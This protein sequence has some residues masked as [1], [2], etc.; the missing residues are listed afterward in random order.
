M[1]PR[2]FPLLTRH[3]LRLSPSGHWIPVPRSALNR[4][5]H[6]A[7]PKPL[8]RR[9]KTFDTLASDAT[10]V[11]S[12]QAVPSPNSLSSTGG[13]SS[14][15]VEQGARKA[16]SSAGAVDVPLPASAAAAGD[17]AAGEKKRTFLGVEVP[18]KPEPPAEGEC[19]MSGCAHCVYDLHLEDLEHYHSLV[20]STRRA[21]LK[22][23]A[24]LPPEEQGRA[25][26]GW[27]EVWGRLEEGGADG[28]GD[29]KERAQRELEETR[30][31]LD[32]G[33]R[34]FLEMEARMKAKQKERER[35]SQAAAA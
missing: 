3:I 11:P 24:A 1:T 8:H 32:P 31:G 22:K 15:A 27:P 17:A 23:L 5:R 12:L 2:P 9:E 30:K 7:P 13:S 10:P 34:A 4:D 21:G 35:E 14:T 29:A 28:G 20:A 33:M 26:G 25:R 18:V 19:C 6:P 16:T